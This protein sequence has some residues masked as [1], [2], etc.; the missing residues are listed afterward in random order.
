MIVAPCG[1]VKPLS[2]PLIR[3]LVTMTVD[4]PRG[5]CAASTIYLPAWMA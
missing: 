1:A 4:G 2:I 5:L 3:P